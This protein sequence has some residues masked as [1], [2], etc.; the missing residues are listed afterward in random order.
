MSVASVVSFGHGLLSRGDLLVSPAQPEPAVALAAPAAIAPPMEIAVAPAARPATPL[1]SRPPGSPA[2]ETIPDETEPAG[3]EPVV[4]PAEDVA[5]ASA[6]EDTATDVV[7]VV[8]PSEPPPP[9]ED[10]PI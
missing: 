5:V 2:P 1:A 3:Q 10:A 4:V 6:A 7:D 9:P 8:E